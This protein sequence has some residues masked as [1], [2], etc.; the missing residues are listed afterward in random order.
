MSIELVMPSNHFI[1]CRPLLFLPSI[2]PSIRVFSNES[3]LHIRW[4][5]YWSFSF[6][7]SPSNE[8]SVLLSFRI[9]WFHLLAV[10]GTLKSLLQHHNSKA[11]VLQCSAFFMIQLSYPYMTTR[12]TIALTIQIFS[13]RHNHSWKRSDYRDLCART[14]NESRSFSFQNEPHCPISP[15]EPSAVEK[16]MATHSSTLAWRIPWMEEP[17]GL[18]SMESQRVGHDWA[19]SLSLF[20]FVHWRR[21][22]QPTVGCRLWGRTELDTTQVT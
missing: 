6:N 14:E 22:W 13:P 16:A 1:L 20:I 5:K 7:I 8:Y 3:A 11:S 18:Q 2:F 15:K 21:K 17:C 19:T 9:D 4:P 10:R 12:K